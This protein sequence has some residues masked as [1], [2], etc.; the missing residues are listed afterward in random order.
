MTR[1]TQFSKEIIIQ[2]YIKDNFINY[3]ANYDT[4]QSIIETRVKLKQKSCFFLFATVG[5]KVDELIVFNKDRT[6]LYTTLN[7]LYSSTAIG[8]SDLIQSLYGVKID[9]E[10][11]VYLGANLIAMRVG[12]KYDKYEPFTW[13]EISFMAH[14]QMFGRFIGFDWRGNLELKSEMV[15]KYVDP[16]NIGGASI[17][18]DGTEEERFIRLTEFES[19][20]IIDSLEYQQLLDEVNHPEPK[21]KDPIVR[22]TWWDK[23]WGAKE[24]IFETDEWKE[25]VTNKS[26]KK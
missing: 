20:Q 19:S 23:L 8:S 10:W 18:Q 4:L 3:E 11:H 9:G 17:S 14:E 26:K 21:I 15:D 7:S 6:K 25:F 13:D 16:E 22:L 1:K 12:Y 2:S 24:P 5:Y